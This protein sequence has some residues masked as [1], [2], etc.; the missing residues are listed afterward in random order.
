MNLAD[1]RLICDKCG[2]TVDAPDKYIKGYW[3]SNC[4]YLHYSN[5]VYTKDIQT[6][7]EFAEEIRFIL[8]E[9][10]RIM[11]K[12]PVEQKVRV[13]LLCDLYD[14]CD[15][16]Q[17]LDEYCTV[18]ILKVLT[19]LIEQVPAS[20]RRAVD[21]DVSREDYI[22]FINYFDM[23]EMN[24]NVITAFISFCFGRDIESYDFRKTDFTLSEPE[25]YL[26]SWYSNTMEDKSI[27]KRISRS[28]K[29]K[30]GKYIRRGIFTGL[31]LAIA[32]CL[33]AVSD[34]MVLVRSRENPSTLPAVFLLATL[35]I[36][37]TVVAIIALEA[38]SKKYKK[39]KNQI[40]DILDKR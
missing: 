33:F 24:L 11:Q 28:A 26:L 34:I 14:L 20:S 16:Q 7:D 21:S 1:G 17:V 36:A 10:Y 3:C 18:S 9:I 22:T 2:A 4:G 35:L 5:H 12:P 37:D 25:L 29:R 19:V 27:Y 38:I 8:A 31:I 40:Y 15:W 13:K 6:A 39:A 32:F 30:Q 23:T